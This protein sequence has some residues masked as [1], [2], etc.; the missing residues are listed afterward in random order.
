MRL[1]GEVIP[2]FS[3]YVMLKIGYGLWYN[4]TIDLKQGPM[5]D[6]NGSF[7]VELKYGE[8]LYWMPSNYK[9]ENLRHD[10]L[11]FKRK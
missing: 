4:E 10:H 2:S 11:C 6:N 1:Y 9:G 3:A 7:Q 8:Q 5:Y